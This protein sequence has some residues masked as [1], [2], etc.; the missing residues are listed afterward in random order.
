M[1]LNPFGLQ[2]YSSS[3]FSYWCSVWYSIHYFNL[4]IEVSIYYCRIVSPFKSVSVYVFWESD[5]RY[6]YE[7]HVLKLY[8]KASFKSYHLFLVYFESIFRIQ[9]YWY[10]VLSFLH[11]HC[12]M[13]FLFICTVTF[14][15][16]CISI[17]I[18][19]S[20][21]QILKKKFLLKLI[22]IPCKICKSIWGGLI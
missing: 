1:S 16:I 12:H 21:C 13:R 7:L 8:V 2:C 11:F 4:S 14:P 10:E 17:Y 6:I 9:P 18:L 19:K 15:V 22:V 3:L 5:V 20:A